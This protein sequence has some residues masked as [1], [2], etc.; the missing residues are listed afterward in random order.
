MWFPP[1]ICFQLRNATSI[2]ICLCAQQSKKIKSVLVIHFR[3]LGICNPIYLSEEKKYIGKTFSLLNCP[4]HFIL[5]E[6]KQ[7]YKMHKWKTLDTINSISNKNTQFIILPSKT[8]STKRVN[9]LVIFHMGIFTT[10]KIGG[11]IRKKNPAPNQMQVFI[12]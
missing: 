1:L 9:K 8:S 7:T 11:I 6:R 3:A 5:N 2:V 12:K 10:K 4:H